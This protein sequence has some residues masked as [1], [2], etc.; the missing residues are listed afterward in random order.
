LVDANRALNCVG[1]KRGSVK[2]VL[3]TNYKPKASKTTK[4]T[5]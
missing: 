2:E 1:D 3:V 5:K 4:E